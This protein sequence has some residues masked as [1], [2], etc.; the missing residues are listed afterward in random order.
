MSAKKGEKTDVKTIIMRKAMQQEK[1]Q[2]WLW[3]GV[4]GFTV[5]IAILWGWSFYNNITL[6]SLEKS[7]EKKLT[8][9]LK[10]SWDQTVMDNKMEKEK[11]K[12][13]KQLEEIL[14]QIKAVSEKNTTTYSTNTSATTTTIITTP[15]TTTTT[16]KI[17]STTKK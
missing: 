16:N 10:N 5:I 14:K 4:G 3:L 11:E 9:D 12:N 8:Q 1:A 6:I 13:T 7:P 17:S 15:T 2:A